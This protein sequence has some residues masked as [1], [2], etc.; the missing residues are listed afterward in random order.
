MQQRICRLQDEMHKWCFLGES[1]C[2]SC[3]PS[4]SLHARM[5]PGR[6]TGQRNKKIPWH[7]LSIIRLSL[8][9]ICFTRA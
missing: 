1:K 8:F 7:R 6:G 2:Y 9:D 4:R 5:P 3:L